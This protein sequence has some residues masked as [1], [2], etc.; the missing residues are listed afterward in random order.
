MS[1]SSPCQ[2]RHFT[3]EMIRCAVRWSLRY[4]LRSRDVE[5][6]LRE[7]GLRVDY[8]TVFRWVQP[9]APALDKRCRP[10]L[11]LRHDSYHVDATYIRS[12]K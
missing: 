6:L 4:S 1:P 12:K 11:R 7:R 3:G 5:E 8:P 2:W 9:Y 10:H